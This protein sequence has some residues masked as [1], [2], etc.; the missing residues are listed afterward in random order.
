MAQLELTLIRMFAEEGDPGW[1]AGQL[2]D[3]RRVHATA[4]ACQPGVVHWSGS[5]EDS[6]ACE[7]S[8]A[9]TCNLCLIRQEGDL[10]FTKV[11]GCYRS[12]NSAVRALKFWASNPD[13][14]QPPAPFNCGWTTMQAILCDNEPN[15]A[16]MPL[17]TTEQPVL[18]SQHAELDPDPCA[19]DHMALKYHCATHDVAPTPCPKCG[20][21]PFI[22]FINLSIDPATDD[23]RGMPSRVSRAWIIENS[24]PE[25]QGV[26]P[27]PAER[28]GGLF[29]HV[30]YAV[31]CD[32]EDECRCEEDD[33]LQWVITEFTN[34][35]M[36]IEAL[37]QRGAP[38]FDAA[39]HQEREDH[40]DFDYMYDDPYRDWKYDLMDQI[41]ADSLDECSKSGHPRQA[42]LILSEQQKEAIICPVCG[43]VPEFWEKGSG[44][45]R[46]GFYDYIS[47]LIG[48]T[49]MAN[50][51]IMAN[52]DDL[53]NVTFYFQ[54]RVFRSSED[55]PKPGSSGLTRLPYPGD[56]A[57]TLQWFRQEWNQRG[58]LPDEAV[59]LHP[60]TKEPLT[61]ETLREVVAEGHEDGFC[62]ETMAIDVIETATK[63]MRRALAARDG[64]RC[65]HCQEPIK[66]HNTI[67]ERRDPTKGDCS[68][69]LH[70]LCQR[71]HRVKKDAPWEQFRK[72]WE[73][74]FG[75]EYVKRVV[76]AL[77]GT[78]DEQ[79][80]EIRLAYRGNADRCK[81]CRWIIVGDYALNEDRHCAHCVVGAPR[82]P[83]F[84]FPPR[85]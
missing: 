46:I 65:Q 40:V 51:E 3:G 11:T 58:Y 48:E 37:N 10:V 4:I 16:P 73:Q 82:R 75:F 59:L 57:I 27:I 76:D 69:N 84:Q 21:T 47:E 79:M 18:R 22:H 24:D 81:S 71:C 9:G 30:R 85:E 32:H 72:D 66:K 29:T 6:T 7:C 34:G 39:A 42:W 52:D 12:A 80:D 67:I 74:R 2:D 19:D 60:Y 26:V 63:E 25:E 64:K 28:R 23:L 31:D 13:A 33:S 77:H 44:D 53:D 1:H 36:T 49:H 35:P 50:H 62:Y 43:K 14:P 5:V 78:D 8:G 38:D 61:D 55:W 45:E 56:D 41:T 20:E 70:L 68:D 17:G 54:T 83:E 15:A